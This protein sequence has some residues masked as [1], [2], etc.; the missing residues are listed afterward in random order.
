M[1]LRD[2]LYGIAVGPPHYLAHSRAQA[3]LQEQKMHFKIERTLNELTFGFPIPHSAAAA[4]SRQL[5]T[6]APLMLLASL[7]GA[8]GWSLA[9]PGWC[10]CLQH[11][12][13]VGAASGRL[14]AGHRMEK[15]ELKAPGNSD[16]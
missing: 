8:A 12:D 3:F 9:V 4:G 10:Q 11:R 14:K 5:H 16:H 1:H 6:A 13:G 2:P 7:P 15:G